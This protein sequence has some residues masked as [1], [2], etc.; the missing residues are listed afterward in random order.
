MNTR[1]HWAKYYLPG[2]FFAEDQAVELSDR[3]I[4][5]AVA[6]APEHAFAFVLYD[7][8]V[9][10]FDFDASLFRVVPIPQNYSA[11]H[12]LGGVI[13]TCDELRALA[14]V[15]G[16]QGKYRTLISNVTNYTATGDPVEGRAIRCVTGNWQPFEDGD[17]LLSTPIPLSP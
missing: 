16:E 12:Y 11:K 8:A 9:P 17:V 6:R 14:L 5:A 7:T 13:Y 10:D 15:E 4:D 3:S 1:K 2:S